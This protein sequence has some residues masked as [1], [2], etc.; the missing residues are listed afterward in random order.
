MESMNAPNKLRC[1]FLKDDTSGRD[2]AEV[3]IIGDPN[4][5]IMK[6]TP[7]LIAQFPREWD[8]Y[9][10]GQKELVIEGT[11][12]TEVPGIDRSMAMG[13]KLKGVRTAEELAGLDEAAAVALGLNMRTFVAS[14]KNLVKLKHLEKMEAMMAASD[15]VKRGPGRPPKTEE[16]A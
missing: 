9:Q 12:L 11:P 4:T 16:A 5:I 13:L 7:E 10:S 8:A 2:M 15:P 14:A 6:V 3:I 1:S